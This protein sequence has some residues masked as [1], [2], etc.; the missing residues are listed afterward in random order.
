MRAAALSLALSLAVFLAAAPMLRAETADPAA[1]PAASSL[2]AIT[3]SVVALQ[4]LDD[5]VLGSGLINAVEQVLVQPQIEGQAIDA[6][7]VEVGD[8]V[9]QGQ[10]LARLSD[11][12]LTLQKSQLQASLAAS[13]A[14]IAQAQAQ[15]I[16]AQTARDEAIRVS[17][18]TKALAEAGTSTQSAAETAAA[19]ATAA[20]AR[21]TVAA[22][23]LIAA[24]AQRTLVEAQIANVDLSLERTNV[25]APVAGVVVGRNAM[26]GAIASGGAGPMF[27]LNRDGQL[28]LRADIDEQDVLRLVA[29][30]RATLWVSRREEPLTG[31][32]R[33]VEPAVDQTTRLGRVRIAI[34]DPAQVRSGMF[35]DTR[36]LLQSKMAI[37]VP[38]SAVGGGASGA[39]ALKVT[40]GIVALVPITTGIRDG[41]LIEVT[42]GLAA[43]DMIVTKAG[44]FVRDGDHINPVMA[45]AAAAGSN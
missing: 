34:D 11:S 18:R 8:K 31:S 35:A 17:T 38:V 10:V 25:T 5:V 3:V 9:D 43:G 36:I 39:T 45:D 16:E 21:V 26:V 28:E 29:G 22:Q 32:V 40:D 14:A 23:G 30:Q 44:A 24:E 15:V 2:P 13:N 1:A 4:P 33:L 7:M 19:S 41:G 27:T 42:S 6:I 12:S 20:A 37:A